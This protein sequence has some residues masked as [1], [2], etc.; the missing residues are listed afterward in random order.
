MRGS[1]A[2][3]TGFERAVRRAI[4]RRKLLEGTDRV[5]VAVS[6]GPDSMALLYALLRITRSG[7]SGPDLLVAH[8]DHGLRPD[9]GR[10]A[11]FVAAAADNAG[12]EAVVGRVDIAAV[13]AERR[14]NLEAAARE[15][16][17][18]FLARVAAERGARAVATA[19]TASDQAETV[20][21][22]V[23][24][25]AGPDGLV[26]IEA[27]RTLAV[28]IRLVRPLLDVARD[29]VLAYCRDREIRFVD[30]VTNRDLERT[31]AYARHEL[32]PRLER[33][34]PGAAA[35]LARTAQLAELDRDFFAELVAGFFEGQPGAAGGRVTLR[36]TDVAGL[37]PALRQRVLRESVRRIRGDLHRVDAGHVEAMERLLGQDPGG[38]GVS[39]PSGV[40]A[41][42]DGEWLV[43]ERDVEFGEGSSVQSGKP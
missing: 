12:L 26:G 29:A 28:D 11:A 20:L 23:A 36:A 9:S 38:G 14:Q 42:R 41:R 35:N 33:V 40:R 10:D 21:M 30:D 31:R 8:L 16:R 1:D 34:A 15:E 19:H 32:L 5:V 43:V 13:A 22:R 18:A 39:L 6:G 24:R 3:L 7:G 27:V 17:Y 4:R 25:G 37:H 2:H